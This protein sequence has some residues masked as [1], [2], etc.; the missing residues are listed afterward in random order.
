MHYLS[1]ILI[2]VL[3]KKWYL[4]KIMEKNV[5]TTWEVMWLVKPNFSLSSQFPPQF[6]F[7]P[8]NWF[9]FNPQKNIQILEMISYWFRTNKNWYSLGRN[10]KYNSYKRECDGN[11]EESEKLGLTNHITSQ[12]THQFF[13]NHLLSDHGKSSIVTSRFYEYRIGWIHTFYVLHLFIQF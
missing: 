11:W 1:S 9:M 7:I 4:R 3:L 8:L 10:W 13:Q 5:V 6:L 12:K 2:I